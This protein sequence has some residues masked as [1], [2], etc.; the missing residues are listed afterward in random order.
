M[1]ANIFFICISLA[2]YITNCQYKSA[3]YATWA[4]SHV[5]WMHESDQSEKAIY[6]LIKGY[7]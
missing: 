1:S 6:E 2:L 7:Q 4:H 3:P 5:V